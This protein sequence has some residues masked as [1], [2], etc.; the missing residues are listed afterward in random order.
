MQNPP[1][2]IIT[3]PNSSKGKVKPSTTKLRQSISTMNAKA[4]SFTLG[5]ILYK[6]KPIHLII[7]IWSRSSKSKTSTQPPTNSAKSKSLHQSLGQASTKK[8]DKSV[9]TINTR[10]GQVP[11]N[12]QT[13]PS[14]FKG[15]IDQRQ[16]G[17]LNEETKIRKGSHHVRLKSHIEACKEQAVKT[18]SEK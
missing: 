7:N 9:H 18:K 2:F 8:Q 15:V 11:S 13:E 4:S 10:L 5:Q 1:Q 16:E 12:D 14:M 3:R 17:S 6:R